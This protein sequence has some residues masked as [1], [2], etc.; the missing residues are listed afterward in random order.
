MM[1]ILLKRTYEISQL[2]SEILNL[3][4]IFYN[5]IDFF[6][7]FI[8]LLISV[9]LGTFMSISF[10][11]NIFKDQILYGILLF[12]LSILSSLQQYMNLRV[13]SNKCKKT[14]KKYKLLYLNI[15]NNNIE[16]Y[17]E[18][19]NKIIKKFNKYKKHKIS[20]II[21]FYYKQI[22]KKQINEYF[23]SNDVNI[24]ENKNIYDYSLMIRDIHGNLFI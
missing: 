22:K 9:Y 14:S 1:N 10:E 8:Q 11:N 12:V 15:I 5:I 20:C 6:I 3:C 2:Y 24:V 16:N 19:I 18:Y 17:D 23:I 13:L 21:M 4:S 7:F